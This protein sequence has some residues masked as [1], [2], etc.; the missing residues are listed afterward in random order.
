MLKKAFDRRGTPRPVRRDYTWVNTLWP[1]SSYNT[2]FSGASL[3]VRF[4]AAFLRISS[5]DPQQPHPCTS[6]AITKKARTEPY[7]DKKLGTTMTG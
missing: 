6:V 5:E 3:P 7:V 2:Y 4:L 1:L